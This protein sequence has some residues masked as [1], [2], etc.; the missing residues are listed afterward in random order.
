[1]I[2]YLD[3]DEVRHDTV[4]SKWKGL[5]PFNEAVALA[6]GWQKMNEPADTEK[7]DNAEL[8]IVEKIVALAQKYNAVE[9]LVALDNINIPSLRALAKQHS[10][11]ARDMAAIEIEVLVLA[12]DLEAIVGLSWTDTWNGLKERFPIYVAHILEN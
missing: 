8:A 10:V 1:M 9:D 2:Y 4:P 12:R 3:E 11:T 5:S 7:R 6:H